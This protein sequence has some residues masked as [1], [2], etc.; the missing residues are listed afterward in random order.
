MKFFRGAL[1]S[2][3]LLYIENNEF[4]SEIFLNVTVVQIIELSLYT[5]LYFKQ[6]YRSLRVKFFKVMNTMLNTIVIHIVELSLY[7]FFLYIYFSEVIS[8]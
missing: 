6:K 4:E 1:E 3:F 2:Y 8:Y 7:F 5:L